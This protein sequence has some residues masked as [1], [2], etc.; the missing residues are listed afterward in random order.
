M[1]Y[2]SAGNDFNIS[3][4][5]SKG[6][7]CLAIFTVLI[8]TIDDPPALILWRV[9]SCLVCAVL[10]CAAQ[11]KIIERC[12]LVI[13]NKRA[14]GNCFCHVVPFFED[15]TFPAGSFRAQV[16]EKLFMFLNSNTFRRSQGLQISSTVQE[17]RTLA[18]FGFEWEGLKSWGPDLW[19]R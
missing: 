11:L 16:S 5:C 9:E 7:I 6:R 10:C 13:S 17:R 8:A 15:C 12:V 14:L 3:F 18:V 2:P 4:G 19:G 1:I